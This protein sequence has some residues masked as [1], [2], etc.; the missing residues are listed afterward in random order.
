MTFLA[1]FRDRS[2]ILIIQ[3]KKLVNEALIP[4][5]LAHKSALPSHLD[6]AISSAC[7]EIRQS[8]K[9]MLHSGAFGLPL[10]QWPTQIIH[11]LLWNQ[12]M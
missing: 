11:K 9:R 3:W 5:K 2:G 1:L 8:G 6:A 10:Y 4:G 12:V 7:S